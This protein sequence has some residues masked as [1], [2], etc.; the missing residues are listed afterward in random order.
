[1]DVKVKMQEAARF[2]VR[3]KSE[4]PNPAEDRARA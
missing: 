4:R 2:D 3:K 1:V